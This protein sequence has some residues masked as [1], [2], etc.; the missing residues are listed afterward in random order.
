MDI[1]VAILVHPHSGRYI[2]GACGS[3]NGP[4]L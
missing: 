3:L 1:I 4:L 2:I